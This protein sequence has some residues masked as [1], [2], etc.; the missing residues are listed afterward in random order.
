VTNKPYRI[1]RQSPTDLDEA[2]AVAPSLEFDY[3]RG[4]QHGEPSW[5]EKHAGMKFGPSLIR[6]ALAA[7]LVVVAEIEGF[8]YPVAVKEARWMAGVLEV[9]ALESW[10][11]PERLF[12]RTTMKG[13]TVGGILMEP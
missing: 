13:F 3:R 10:K 11:V 1:V 6:K 7:G 2:G 8:P 5:P 9:S 12:T 4:T